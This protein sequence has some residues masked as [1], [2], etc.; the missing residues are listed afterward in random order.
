MERAHEGEEAR[1][2]MREQ[3]RGD[4]RAGRT[5]VHTAVGAVGVTTWLRTPVATSPASD[6]RPPA[7]DPQKHIST[8]LKI[9]LTAPKRGY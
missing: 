1:A 5:S 2:H 4:D 6:T 9:K 7:F 8:G 3:R